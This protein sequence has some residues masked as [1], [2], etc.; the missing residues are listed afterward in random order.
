MSTAIIFTNNEKEVGKKEIV[1]ATSNSKKKEEFC[2]LLPNIELK[3]EPYEHPE[4]Q[5]VP[6]EIA[7]HKAKVHA[8]E[9]N[10]PVIIEDTALYLK[11]MPGLGGYVKYYGFDSELNYSEKTQCDNLYKC[12]IG[13]HDKTLIAKCMIVYCEPGQEPIV[14]QG[15]FTGE[16]CS[17]EQG[18][19]H[20]GGKYFGWD[21]IMFDVKTNKSF[22]QMTPD[23]KDEVSPRGKAIK[24]FM[25]WYESKL[26]I[27]D[28]VDDA[29][30]KDPTSRTYPVQIVTYDV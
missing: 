11:E 18:K 26:S 28:Y 4:I 9:K 12:S 2:R 19:P 10:K 8:N 6:L 1:I 21:P 30:S 17:F 14:F 24:M 3:F 22:A 16:I 25:E 7:M 23:E 13:C 29:L 27:R 20:D 15:C 5:G